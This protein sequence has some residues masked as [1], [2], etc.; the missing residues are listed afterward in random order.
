MPSSPS[1]KA[2]LLKRLVA[3]RRRYMPPGSSETLGRSPA[4]DALRS[5]ASRA[6]SGEAAKPATQ[7]SDAQSLHLMLL[8]QQRFLLTM[9]TEQ[10][11]RLREQAERDQNLERMVA[12]SAQ[13]Q[14][15]RLERLNEYLRQVKDE[16]DRTCHEFANH[17]QKACLTLDRVASGLRGELE[18]WQSLRR[19]EARLLVGVLIL[20]ALAM[21]QGLLRIH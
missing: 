13:E 21:I 17:T 5:E 10:S 15:A 7:G 8:D 16:S 11:L 2:A 9:M 6:R 1:P 14:K 19:K 20:S 18:A 12:P 3:A 4:P